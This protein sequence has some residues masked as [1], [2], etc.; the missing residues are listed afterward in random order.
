MQ[1]PVLPARRVDSL[2]PAHAL[3]PS[4]G[5]PAGGGVASGPTGLVI[6]AEMKRLDGEEKPEIMKKLILLDFDLLSPFIRLFSS[7]ISD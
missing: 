2:K 6:A 5:R 3:D 4:P 1:G 7:S